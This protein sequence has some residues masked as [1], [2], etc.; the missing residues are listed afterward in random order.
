M[1]S[2]SHDETREN[3]PDADRVTVSVPPTTVRLKSKGLDSPYLVGT[4]E[5]GR[6][7]DKGSCLIF[8]ETGPMDL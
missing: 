7:L 1:S 4:Y 2:A 6:D 5:G 8:A 3:P